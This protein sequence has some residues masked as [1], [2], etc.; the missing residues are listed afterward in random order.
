MTWTVRYIN[1]QL[2]RFPAEYQG[3]ADNY[4]LQADGTWVA[5]AGGGAIDVND[6]G[7][8]SI[9][10]PSVG[11]TI[12][13]TGNGG[14]EWENAYATTLIEVK[15]A[16]TVTTEEGEAP[17]TITKGQAV[18][19]SGTSGAGKPEVKLAD[20]DGSGT[21]PAI[22]L[23]YDDIAGDGEGLVIAAGVLDQLSVTQSAGTALY[24]D[25][26]TPGALTGTRPTGSSEKVQKVALV[27]RT[28]SG[29]GGN[30]SVI[31]MG[32]GRTNDINNELVAL[33][34]T[35][36]PNDTDLGTFTGTT[37]ADNETVK[38]ALQDLETAVETTDILQRE[39]GHPIRTISSTTLTDLLSY[40][41]VGG[42]M[43]VGDSITF[44]VKGE[45]IQNSGS[46][47]NVR[48]ETRCGAVSLTN[49]ATQFTNDADPYGFEVTGEYVYTDDT[50]FDKQFILIN[51]RA[52]TASSATSGYGNIGGTAKD[53]L[54]QSTGGALTMSSNQTLEV[55]GRFDTS[56]TGCSINVYSTEVRINRK[57]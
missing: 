10:D 20:A 54:S 41:I 23:V 56:T 26:T 49:S 40:Q 4:V 8:V 39:N 22:G 14:S 51:F 11:Q 50:T 2:M 27:T 53:G 18:Y 13:Y 55:R 32:A 17:A 47:Q 46:N 5:N 36:G 44:S 7:D 34:G 24:I 38:G 28:E 57:P 33:L 25:A 30:G 29:A 16:H 52:G 6:L 15:N 31:V 43:A 1:N 19:V 35:T 9:S 3:I 42:T 48:I 45:I 21:H 37:I 12:I